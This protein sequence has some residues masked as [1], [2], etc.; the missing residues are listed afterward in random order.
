MRFS[1][2]VK[3]V[4][5]KVAKSTSN[6]GVL[7]PK[8]VIKPA[9]IPQIVQS[10]S[11]IAAV[12]EGIASNQEDETGNKGFYDRACYAV[13]VVLKNFNGDTLLQFEESIKKILKATLGEYFNVFEF[14]RPLLNAERSKFKKVVRT[15][16]ENDKLVL[17]NFATREAD[18]KHL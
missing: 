16:L 11:W 6:K 15:V 3:Y 7:F 1:D 8:I 5:P 9:T 10:L 18:R 2:F 14:L 13:L 17:C 12:A 4:D